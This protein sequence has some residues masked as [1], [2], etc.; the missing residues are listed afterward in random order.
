MLI[1][2]HVLTRRR[3][4]I[5]ETARWAR[6]NWGKIQG[7]MPPNLAGRMIRLLYR[8]VSTWRDLE[9]ME[10]HFREVGY[11]HQVLYSSVLRQE[12]EKAVSR[13]SWCERD[14]SEKQDGWFNPYN[15]TV[16]LA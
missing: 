2:L 7:I 4:G 5:V 16:D 15:S 9:E 13:I 3:A 10:T 11:A 12:R 6:Q 14:S 1:P 8:G